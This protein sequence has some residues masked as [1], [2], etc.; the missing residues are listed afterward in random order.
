MNL[1]VDE[2]S[3]TLITGPSSSGK[4]TLL[5]ALS[6][7]IPH[8]V[9][10][11]SYEG[12]VEIRGKTV[13]ETSFPELVSEIGIV[14]Q[15]PTS[16][17]FGMT[18]EEDIVFGLENLCLERR[19]M[20]RILEETLG[21]VGLREHRFDDPNSLSG[22]E[23]QR[24]V[25][26]SILAMNP[27]ILFLDEPTSN[28]DP[29]GAREV[30]R[31]LYRLKE[32]GKTIILVERKIEHIAPF[33]DDIIAVDQGRVVFQGSPREFYSDPERIRR[34]GVNAPQVVLLAHRLRERG[35]H[36]EGVPLTLEEFRELYLKYRRSVMS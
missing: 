18:V 5:Y 23:R 29:V 6:G 31:T 15:N 33:V 19:D 14:L 11:E 2:G 30:L 21:L 7:V 10:V 25:I 28:L 36:L 32:M 22:G 27:K 9:D 34:L 24:T 3:L 8:C 16:Q 13:S 17:I 4:T 20:E 1:S 12:S 26:G 35:I